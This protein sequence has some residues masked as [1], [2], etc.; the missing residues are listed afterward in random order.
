MDATFTAHQIKVTLPSPLFSYL[1]EQAERFGLTLSGYIKNL[2]VDEV[3]NQ[4]F[5]TFKMSR[6]TEKVAQEA[7]TDYR[8]GKTKKLKNIGELISDL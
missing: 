2:I 1:R 6:N 4:S 7:L 3:K 5:P 8:L